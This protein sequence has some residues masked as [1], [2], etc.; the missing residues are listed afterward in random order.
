[1]QSVLIIGP[2]GVLGL[3]MCRALIENR[4][5]FTRIAAFNNTS[6]D[7]GGALKSQL[8][9]AFK[10]G[11]MEIVDGQ[12]DDP[13]VFKGLSLECQILRFLNNYDDRLRLRSDGSRKPRTSS[14][15]ANH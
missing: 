10:A 2:T 3:S 11:G 13:Q 14:P 7:R 12:Y 8:L 4:Q 5:H 9:A 6:T 1:M 15:T